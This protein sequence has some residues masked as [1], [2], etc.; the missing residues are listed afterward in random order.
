MLINLLCAM[1]SAVR[2]GWTWKGDPVDE[3][4]NL[5]P[6]TRI[7]RVGAV[8]LFYYCTASKAVLV[9]QE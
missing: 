2:G 1:G 6:V 9:Q 7:I 8:S 3:S 4:G 5:L